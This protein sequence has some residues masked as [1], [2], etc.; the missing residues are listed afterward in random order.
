MTVTT[1]GRDEIS[2]IVL[3]DEI[4]VAYRLTNCHRATGKGADAPPSYVVCRACYQTVS[5][6]FGE[7]WTGDE[8]EELRK[9]LK[10]GV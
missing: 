7:A 2:E 9:A 3:N 8:I 5:P 6:E 10:E 1:L 4:G